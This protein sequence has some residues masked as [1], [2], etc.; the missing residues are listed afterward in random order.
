MEFSSPGKFAELLTLAGADAFLVNTD[1]LE[2]GGKFSDL[3]EVVKA[4][5]KAKPNN[6]PACIVKDI[7]IHPVQVFFYSLNVNS[8]QLRV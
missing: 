7:I 3:A 6:P 8:S 2:Y 4:V 5:K 1:E